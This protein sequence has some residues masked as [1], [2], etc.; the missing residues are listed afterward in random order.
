VLAVIAAVQIPTFDYWFYNDD[1]VP[2]GEIARAPSSWDY[3]WRLITVQDITPNWR[4]VPGLV[5]LG[6]YK[7]F[8]MEPLPY[9][10]VST[11]FH[12]GTSALIFHLLRRVTGQAWAGMLGAVIFGLNPAH[13]F[14]V[15]QITSLNNV[16]GA[17]FAV[18]TLVCVYESTQASPWRA[19]VALYVTAVISFVLAIASNES[20]AILAPVYA[21]TFL[22][23]DQGEADIVPVVRRTALETIPAASAHLTIH[24]FVR[25]SGLSLPFAIIGAAALLSFFACGCN[26]AS[27]AFFGSRNVGDNALIYP[28]GIAYPVGGLESLTEPADQPA[29]LEKIADGVE[30]VTGQR[31][32]SIE[33]P[34]FVATILVFALVAIVAIRGPDLARVGAAFMLLAI[35]PYLYVQVFAAPRYTYQ[36]TAG[37]ALLIPAVLVALHARAPLNWRAALSVAVIPLIAA[38]A[39]WYS[40][41]TIEQSEPYKRDTDAWEQLV[42]D[43]ERVFPDVPPKSQVVII[44][45]PW[46]GPLYQFHVMPSIG[47]TMWDPSVRL[48]SV[49][50]EMGDAEIAK[51]ESHWLMARYEGDELIVV[52]P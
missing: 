6:G 18:A 41:Q 9:H 1:Y 17:F 49:P 33:A 8:G 22:F 38:L 23:W 12:L 19:Q 30:R 37:F 43:I 15:A 35:V 2:F 4:V 11:G 31:L 50:P 34:H 16:Q 51:R 3:V 13:V 47:H 5:Y 40:W 42:K 27:S 14:T 52:P 10:F 48:Y 45:G 26:E 44:G 24:R 20:M 28:G 21:L 39:G 46:S 32:D 25:A 36:A 7:L 29:W